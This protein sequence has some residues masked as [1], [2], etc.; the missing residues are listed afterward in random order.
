[1]CHSI[2]FPAKPWLRA[3]L[4]ALLLASAPWAAALTQADLK[5]LAEDD[6]DAKTAALSALANASP[7]EAGPILK[8]LQDDA[9]QYAPSAGMVRQ[10]G[11]KL[12]DAITGKPVTVK[13]DELES[14][15]L[16][17]SL[18]ALVD[19]A[20]SSLLLQ[21]PDIAVRAQAVATLRDQPESA[22][23]AAVEAARKTEADAGL[24]ASLDVIW[25][26]L[27]LAATPGPAARDARLEAIRILGRDSN[28]QSR[29]KLAPLVER[30]SAG[31]YREPDG[32]VRLAAQQAL[33]TL[34]GDQRRAEV[35]GNL[36]AGL[37]LGSV[38]LL[39]ALGLAITY[40]LIGV[41]NMAHGEF[42]MIGAYA[43]YVVQSLFRA[44]AP[45]ALDWYLPAALPASFL[46]AA[47]VGF[48][49][50]RLVLRHLYGRPLE[51]LL[52]TFG[53]SLL[54]MQAVRTLFGAQNVEVSNP[55]W[56]SG[57]FEWLPGLVIPYNRVVI[58][59]FALAVVAVAWAV[60]NRT[61][62]GLF[63]RATTQNRT[64]AACVG[65]RTWKVDS[66]A[67]AFGAGIAGLGGCALSQIGNVGPDLGQAYIIDS[68]MVVVL[69]GVGQLA[70]TI[71]GA[72]GLGIL[73]KFIEPFYGAVLAK[74]LV[75]VLIVL[76]IQKRPQ[77][78]FAL[79]GRSAE[80]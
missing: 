21:S 8:A 42:L 57:G 50:E 35:I 61:R 73:N 29:Q 32:G 71:V 51:T 27:V 20:A 10:D 78:L 7:D 6:F 62:L 3:L 53:V 59:L 36:F 67:F 65:V 77:G 46:A 13:A 30:D 24:R 40:G 45:G 44:Y 74:I 2:S 54:L 80:A 34:Q 63:V 37:S 18:R 55:A 66:Y 14:L 68:F 47:V 64:M 56:M 58:I 75:L 16:N 28:P 69:G 12:V 25:A 33:D 38:L 23:L 70:G 31:R 22:S 26:N 39:A 15:T 72:F 17:N 48:V 79:K 41:I 5:P 11:D 49:L 4:A 76:F 52:A 19:S 9:L 1:M 43:T 60:L